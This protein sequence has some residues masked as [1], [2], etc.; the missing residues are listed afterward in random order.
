MS[1]HTF[2]LTV[3][4]VLKQLQVRCLDLFIVSFPGIS[5]DRTLICD[6]A[7]LGK[8]SDA[9]QV[10]DL[11]SI[12]ATWQSIESLKDRGLVSKIG[13]S[14]FNKAKLQEFLPRTKIQPSIDQIN[15]QDICLIPRPFIEYTSQ[16]RIEVLTH[17]DCSNI[18][19]TGTLRDLL[20]KGEKGAGIILD[21]QDSGSGLKGDIQP[22][23][24]IKYTA[25]V[26]DR[27]VIEDKGYF[28]MAELDG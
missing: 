23:W 27:G 25:I 7:F 8:T 3:E 24:V 9:S 18:L 14:E 20:G 15:L 1:C 6:D 5:Y 2:V 4:L 13:V 26:R 28:A 22:Q 10:E 19:P 12:V 11:E 21:P 16:Q 17:V